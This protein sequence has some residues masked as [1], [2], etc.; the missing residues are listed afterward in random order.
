MRPMSQERETASAFGAAWRWAVRD[1]PVIAG[2]LVACT[3]GGAVLG[4]ALLTP[5]WSVARRI[6]GGAVGGAGI[7][8]IVTATRMIGW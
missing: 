4:F 5:E 2:V 8:L 1:H 7:G 3:L 6:A